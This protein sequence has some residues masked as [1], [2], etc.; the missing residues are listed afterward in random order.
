M[1]R[2]ICIGNRYVVEDAAGPAVHDFLWRRPLPADIEVIDGGL[3]GLDLLR[4]VEGAERVVFVDSL[5]GYADKPGVYPLDPWAVVAEAAGGYGHESGLAYLLRVLP[6]VCEGALPEIF[7]IGIEG[8]LQEETIAE[9]ADLALGIAAGISVRP[10]Q[11][12][13]FPEAL[14][15]N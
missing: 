5:M 6:A 14:R 13:V 7:L 11:H 9:A 8:P 12:P 10:A 1:N 2:I 4:T 3:A 15:E